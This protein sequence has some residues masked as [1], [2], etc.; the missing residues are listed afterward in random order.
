MYFVISAEESYDCWDLA[1]IC[2]FAVGEMLGLRNSVLMPQVSP[3]R[4]T[5]DTLSFFHDASI[6]SRS[7]ITI[8]QRT[9]FIQGGIGHARSARKAKGFERQGPMR[10][11]I[12]CHR[13]PQASLASLFISMFG[14]FDLVC[15][16]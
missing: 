13:M 12:G 7:K 3:K 4:Y 11:A 6:T 10:P 15:S 16:S 9:Q 1:G 8:M 14:L 5:L 2:N